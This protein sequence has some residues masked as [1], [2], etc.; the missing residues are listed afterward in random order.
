MRKWRLRS[1][2]SGT[3]AA[4]WPVNVSPGLA[5]TAIAAGSPSLSRPAS[6]SGHAGFEL[7][8]ANVGDDDDRQVAGNGARVVVALDDEAGDR[9]VAASCRAALRVTRAQ[10]GLGLRQIRLREVAL[11]DGRAVRGLRR[12]ETLARQR[13]ALE[14][15]LGAIVLGHRVGQ[16]R[17]RA[18]D[19]RVRDGDGG[20]GRVDLRVDFARDRSSRP[21]GRR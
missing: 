20:N 8:L 1:S 7:Q 12:V 19:R 4:S 2:T 11:R 6:S 16:R 15:A 10:R 18:F 9:R 3:I 17:L 21:P 14:Q 5:C 13:A